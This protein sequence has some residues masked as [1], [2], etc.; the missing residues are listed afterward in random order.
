MLNEV[1]LSDSYVAPASLIKWSGFFSSFSSSFFSFL[2]STLGSCTSPQF[3]ALCTLVKLYE[4]FLC[5]PNRKRSLSSLDAD[6]G[7]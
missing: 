1:D 7:A 2:I 6:A 5:R 3:R 4:L